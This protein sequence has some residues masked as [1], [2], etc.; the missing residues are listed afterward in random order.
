LLDLWNLS[1]Q[2]FETNLRFE[3][4]VGLIPFALNLQPGMI[5]NFALV[6]TYHTTP[7]QPPSGEF[8]QLPVE[9][10]LRQLLED[11]YQPPTD[12]QVRLDGAQIRVLNGTANANWDRVAASR[13]AWDGLNASAVGSAD[14]SDYTDTVLIDYEGGSKGSSRGEIAKILNVKPENIRVEP[15]PNREVDFEV[16][17][18]SSYN[19][20]TFGVLP[21]EG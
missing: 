17:I 8:V 2:I 20:C 13:L 18:G 5:E 15:D 3:D 16:I 10:T 4:I 12:S 9:D 6:R 7:W 1:S 19:S 21:V 14:A 11:F